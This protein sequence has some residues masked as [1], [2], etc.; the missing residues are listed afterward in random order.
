MA[1]GRDQE[2]FQTD[3]NALE[4]LTVKWQ[5]PFKTKKC[6][7]MYL[8][9]A[10]QT[11]RYHIT[12]EELVTV[13][14]EKDLAIF[15]DNPLKFHEQTAAAVRLANRIFGLIKCIIITLDAHT[16]PVLFKTMVTP[17][18]EYL[19]TVWGPTSR[20]DQD[21]IDQVQRRATKLIHSVCHLIYQ[22]SL[23]SLKLPSMYYRRLRDDVITVCL[24]DLARASEGGDRRPTGVRSL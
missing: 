15:I 23:R 17:H 3:I 21:A 4:A 11:F 1:S 5:F 9:N 12:K 20:A 24:P 7:L 8:G 18:L 10:N 14:T 13:K 19:N 22:D 16:L 2:L 6:K